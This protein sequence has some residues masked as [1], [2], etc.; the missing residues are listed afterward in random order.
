MK[1]W[2]AAVWTMSIFALANSA[3]GVILYDTGDP[4]ANTA[5]PGGALADSGWQ[6]EGEWGGFLGTPI[7]PHFF[8]SAA[9]I[10]NAGNS[11]FVYNGTTYTATQSYSLGGSDLIIWQVRETFPSFAPLYT[12]RTEIGK[13]LVAIGRGTDRGDAVTLNAALRGWN[14]GAVRSI[15]R[16]GENDVVDLVSYQGHDLVY[17][18]FQAAA[19]P[20]ECH[21][22]VGDSGGAIFLNDSG[23]W[24]LAGIHYSVDDLYTAPDPQTA[25][26][27]A[28]F[29]ARGFYSYDG[30]TFTQITGDNPVPTGFYSSRIASELAWI[31]RVIAQPRMA[32]EGNFLTLSYDRIDA[33]ATDLVYQIE[34]SSDLASW[35]EATTTDEIG[36]S[37]GGISTVKAKIDISAVPR[38]FL[39]LRVTRPPP[40][41]SHPAAALI[42]AISIHDRLDVFSRRRKVNLPKKISRRH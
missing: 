5:A 6:Y 2:T 4:S 13:H 33:P 17:A 22:S 16:W 7:A 41:E 26:A 21:L 29:D 36:A 15:E 8:I 18:T 25:F 37:N 9:H 14:W 38:L 28:I 11:L 3:R 1:R 12:A 35:Q 34:Q 20:N 23:R 10:G 24:K 39:R 30:A 42:K 32:R 40:N 19:S 27:A 31:G